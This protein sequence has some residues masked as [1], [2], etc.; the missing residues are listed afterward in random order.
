[1]LDTTF[2]ALV[3]SAIVAAPFFAAN[4]LIYVLKRKKRGPFPIKST[5]FF[6]IPVVL[7]F[8][9]SWASTAIAEGDVHQFWNALSPNYV[10]SINGRPADNREE[11]LATLKTA[12]SLMAHHSHPT[13]TIYIQISDLPRHLSLQI[14]RDSEDPHEYWVFVS[15]PSQLASR[16]DL[17][18]DIGHVKTSVFDAY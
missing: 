13:H 4:W 17:K 8:I 9:T 16:G 3:L 12:H 10:V 2:V 5:L 11:I 18:A 14:A 6:M 1:M 15:S 7:C